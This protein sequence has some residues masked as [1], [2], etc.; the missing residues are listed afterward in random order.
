MGAERA[1]KTAEGDPPGQALKGEEHALVQP[2]LGLVAEP[3]L[4]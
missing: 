4:F 1:P 2:P 3:D